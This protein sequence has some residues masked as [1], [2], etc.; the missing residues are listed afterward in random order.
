MAR[1]RGEKQRDDEDVGVREV[2]GFRGGIVA[3]DFVI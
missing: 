2:G 1:E 3:G